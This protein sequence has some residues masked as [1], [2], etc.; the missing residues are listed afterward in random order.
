MWVLLYNIK[1]CTVSEEGGNG[2]SLFIEEKDLKLVSHRTIS[3]KNSVAFAL[4]DVLKHLT[5]NTC[6]VRP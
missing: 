5:F 3:K 1:T 2:K 4:S 6:V